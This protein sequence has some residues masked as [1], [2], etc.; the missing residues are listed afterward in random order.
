MKEYR[1]LRFEMALIV[2]SLFT[3][4]LVV[5]IDQTFPPVSMLKVAGATVGGAI[6][7]AA[8]Y[9]VNRPKALAK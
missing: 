6:A 3:A 9:M 5:G 4:V 2:A 1:G 8:I 7:G